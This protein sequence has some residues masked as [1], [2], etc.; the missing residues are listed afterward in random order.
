MRIILKIIAAPFVVVLTISG[1]VLIFL[2]CWAEMILKF[3]SGIAGLVAVILL[4]A[5]QTPGGI[6]FAVITFLISPVGIPAF[7]KWLIDKL[8]DLN[9]TLKCFIT[10]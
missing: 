4:F 3:A 1:A 5:G 8:Y 10:S 9:D 2:F 6:V 7:A